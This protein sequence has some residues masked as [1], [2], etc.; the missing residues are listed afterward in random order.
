MDRETPGHIDSFIKGLRLDELNS[1]YL[2]F[3]YSDY[4]SL[5]FAFTTTVTSKTNYHQQKIDSHQRKAHLFSIPQH[6]KN[7]KMF[8][9]TTSAVVA[10]T[11]SPSARLLG[12][13][14]GLAPGCVQDEEAPP[15]RQLCEK[16]YN[17]FQLL[18]PFCKYC[19][20]L[21]GCCPGH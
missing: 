16:C 17:F 6:N 14:C 18:C 1:P 11:T 9:K 13:L 2:H 21:E 4:F 19:I 15:H 7:K 20:G 5:P 8:K 3:E 10:T 12:V